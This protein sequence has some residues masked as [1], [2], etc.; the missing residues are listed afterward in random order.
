MSEIEWECENEVCCEY[1]ITVFSPSE[2]LHI[3]CENCGKDLV[4]QRAE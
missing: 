3:K 1:D 2:V 4:C